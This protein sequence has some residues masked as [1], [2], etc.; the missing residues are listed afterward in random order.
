MWLKFIGLCRDAIGTVRFYQWCFAPLR[1]H[2]ID[3]TCHLRFGVVKQSNQQACSHRSLCCRPRL[4]WCVVAVITVRAHMVVGDI[5]EF[6]HGLVQFFLCPKFVQICTFVLQS[7]EVP[8]HRRI[9]V[10][11]SGFAH[12]L[13]HIGRFAELYESF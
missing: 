7:V 9:V 10:W 13:G 8:L 3:K 4:V 2:A 12:A 11:I 1:G 5:G 6:L